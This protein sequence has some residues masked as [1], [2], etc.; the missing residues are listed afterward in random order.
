MCS[1]KAGLGL[2]DRQ[3]N[4][5]VELV[6]DGEEKLP[7]LVFFASAR[8]PEGREIIADYGPDYWKMASRALLQAHADVQ[9]NGAAA[10]HRAGT[11]SSS[12]LGSTR[13]GDKTGSRTRSGEAE[14]HGK[15]KVSRSR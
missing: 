10:S 14:G 13:G 4:C 12:S 6:Y 2:P 5:Y 15:N 3:P 11:S 7:L 1:D 9:A 8:I